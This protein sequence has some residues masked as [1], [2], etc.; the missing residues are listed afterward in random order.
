MTYGERGQVQL[1]LRNW[2]SQQNFVQ[3]FA[4]T[5]TLRQCVTVPIGT[6]SARMWINETLASQNL[7]HFLNKLNRS[8]FGKAAIRFNKSVACIPIL[9]GGTH[10]RLHYHLLLDCPRADLVE[11][12]PGLIADHWRSSMWG[13]HQLDC[14]RDPDA[15]WV[16]YMTKFRDKTDF[17]DAIDWVNVRLQ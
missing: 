1:I 13:Y 12:F 2:I 15:G 3:P 16:N 7:R 5:L 11:S 9:E 14:Q 4:V 17:A 6:P 8:I 10:K